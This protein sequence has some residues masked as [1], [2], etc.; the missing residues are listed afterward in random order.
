MTVIDLII[1]QISSDDIL[2][3]NVFSEKYDSSIVWSLFS[4]NVTW[5][6]NHMVFSECH[7]V[8]KNGFVL[9]FPVYNNECKIKLI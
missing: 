2:Y 6:N 5:I 1:Q 8:N 4:F 7:F 9:S 3:F